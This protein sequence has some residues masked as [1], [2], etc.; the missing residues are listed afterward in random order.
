MPIS[1]IIIGITVA[2]SLIAFSR[3]TL[4][5][6][7]MFIPYLVHKDRQYERFLS[8]G[9]IHTGFM[10]LAFNMYVLFMFGP[11][12]EVYFNQAFGTLGKFIYVAFYVMAIIVACTP[13]FIRHKNNPNY[14]ALGASG[15]VAAIFF[16]FILFNPASPLQII[17]IP[18]INF[19]SVVFGGLYLLYE[20]Y[21]D[22]KMNDKIGHAAHYTGAIFGFIFPLILKPKL[23]LMFVEQVKQL[24]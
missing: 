12:V 5:E 20:F 4:N 19:P 14:R 3:S 22:F 7:L 6:R 23:A 11:M 17:F 13:S 21:A 10:H 24:L 15:G 2:I 18:G 1:Y 16:A 9:F 8:C